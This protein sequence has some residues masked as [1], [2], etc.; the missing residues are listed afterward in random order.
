MICQNLVL[1]L[2]PLTKWSS[3]QERA[4]T[5]LMFIFQQILPSF[6]FV[7]DCNSGKLVL[8]LPVDILWLLSRLFDGRNLNKSRLTEANRSSIESVYWGTYLSH[9]RWVINTLPEYVRQCVS[10]SV[11]ALPSADQGIF[12]F[13][14]FIGTLSCIIY[15]CY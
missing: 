14:N 2:M 8:I 4:G 12:A 6:I 5:R 13:A 11:G 9:L 1:Q 10:V 15:A 3:C 7:A